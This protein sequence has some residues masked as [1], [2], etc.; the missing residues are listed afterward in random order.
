M[1]RHYI[2]IGIAGLSI[3]DAD[4]LKKTLQHITPDH[5]ILQWNTASDPHLDCLLVYEYF[6]E[7]EG[8]Q[9]VLK[10]QKC[11]Y[12]CISK[13]AQYSNQIINNTL[14]L[15]LQN[16]QILKHWFE[17]NVLNSEIKPEIEEPIFSTLVHSQQSSDHPYTINFFKE[18][19][20]PEKGKLH[21]YDQHGTIAIIDS[22]KNLVWLNKDRAETGT[23]FS[24]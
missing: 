6:L 21:L 16:T 12:L 13:N 3:H 4:E 17:Q 5:F 15:P 19:L 7:T 22:A 11:P 14:A 1:H 23:D 8:I 24:F 20:H 2:H 9:R 18:M 10:N